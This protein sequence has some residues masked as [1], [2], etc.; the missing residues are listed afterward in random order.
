MGYVRRLVTLTPV[1]EQLGVRLRQQALPMDL[2]LASFSV[3][4]CWHKLMNVSAKSCEVCLE[5]LASS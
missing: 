5:S 2:T 4:P 1:K 3:P